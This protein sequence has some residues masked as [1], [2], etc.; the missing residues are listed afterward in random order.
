MV[1]LVKAAQHQYLHQHPG[2]GGRR[3]RRQDAQE[4]RPGPGG[5]RGAHIGADHV[6]GTVGQIDHL[7]DAENQG[8]PGGHEKQHD[9]QL[10][11]V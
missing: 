7:H 2:K 6:E 10:E 8:Q 4:K 9:A 3:Q 5:H 1:C 11:T